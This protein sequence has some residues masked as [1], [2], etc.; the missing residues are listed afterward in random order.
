MG[1]KTNYTKLLEEREAVKKRT[2]ELVTSKLNYLRGIG[3]SVLTKKLGHGWRNDELSYLGDIG[4]WLKH[5]GELHALNEDAVELSSAAA[6]S[7]RPKGVY[8]IPIRFLRA[9]DRDFAHYLRQKIYERKEYLRKLELDNAAKS[10]RDIELDMDKKN[11]ELVRLQNLVN[12]QKDKLDKKKEAE[13]EKT[14]K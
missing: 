6:T 1:S 9:S 11:K 8:K 7:I 4:V 10:I 5:G 3:I 14:A 2:E 12:D 13:K